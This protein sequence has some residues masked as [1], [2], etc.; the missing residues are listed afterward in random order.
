MKLRLFV[1]LFLLASAAWAHRYTYG[2]VDCKVD[3]DRAVVYVNGQASGV[4][5]DFDGWPGYLKLKPGDYDL[6]FRL[7]GY[8]T[9]KAHVTVVAGEIVKVRLTLK[10]L[11]PSEFREENRVE[12]NREKPAENQPLEWG[13]L[14][15][16]L[17]PEN[18]VA[19]MD[20]RL[21]ATA[22]DLAKVHSPL[23]IAAGRHI[24]SCYAPGYAEDTRES[25]LKPG[26]LIE[27]DVVLVK[28]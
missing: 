19:Y 15:L 27:L 8:E 25:D 6:E 16:H 1:I 28:K 2:A 10:R 4:A 13:R 24:I 18:A 9:G 3:P 11:P 17:S 21:L 5:D 7:G 26:E 22:A 23:Q 14:R 20:G 12:E